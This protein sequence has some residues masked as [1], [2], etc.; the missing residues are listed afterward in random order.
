MISHLTIASTLD[1]VLALSVPILAITLGIGTGMLSLFLNYKK[2]R[3]M[4]AMYHQQRMA[5]IDKGVELPP[6]PAEFFMEDG[7]SNRPPS[8]HR[9]LLW[10][11]IFLLVSVG[12]GLALYFNNQETKAFYAF[13]P[14]G[15]GFACILYYLTVGRREA[16]RAEAAAASA[17][18]GAGVSDPRR[19]C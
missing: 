3:E 5:A 8:P 6:M 18:A 4:F 2:R 13:I 16:A 7:R 12:T 1:S 14:G 9:T 11:L 10:G 19:A 15:V 17:S